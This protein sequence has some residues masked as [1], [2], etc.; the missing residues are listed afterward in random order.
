MM[1]S[2]IWHEVSLSLRVSGRLSNCWWQSRW[3]L[4]FGAFFGSSFR[5]GS[6]C[7]VV[8]RS[9]RRR[10]RSLWDCSSCS[11][12]G[13]RHIHWVAEGGW[14]AG[15]ERCCLLP[16][17][18]LPCWWTCYRCMALHHSQGSAGRLACSNPGYASTLPAAMAAHIPGPSSSVTHW[19]FHLRLQH[20]ATPSHFFLL[21]WFWVHSEQAT[22]PPAFWPTSWANT[23]LWRTSHS[24]SPCL[25]SLESVNGLVPGQRL[26]RWP[27]SWACKS[28]ADAASSAISVIALVA[29]ASEERVAF[30]C[31]RRLGSIGLI[32]CDRRASE[33][34]VF[35]KWPIFALQE[36]IFCFRFR[37]CSRASCKVVEL[38]ESTWSWSTMPTEHSL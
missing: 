33:G 38:A 18:A 14:T 5:R 1:L 34:F 25:A 10:V 35:L 8:G 27:S 3:G 21:A 20:S 13:H 26:V 7:I 12:N 9:S 16:K 23:L 31:F 15:A 36:L 24:C 4:G 6:P 17:A 30:S 37:S 19:H 22:A 11:R 2:I 32:L 28:I 29:L